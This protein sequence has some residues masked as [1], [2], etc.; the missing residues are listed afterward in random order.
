[1]NLDE[2][3]YGKLRFFLVA[4]RTLSRRSEITSSMDLRSIALGLSMKGLSGKAIHQEL[5]QTLGVEA[6]AYP[7][8]TWY[9]RAAKFPAQSKEAPDEAREMRADSGNTAILKALT[10]NPFSSVRELLR[11]T[12]MSR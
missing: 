9:L 11:L 10:D 7:T 3:A 2:I 6:V 1:M 12:C 4:K 8:V 5:V